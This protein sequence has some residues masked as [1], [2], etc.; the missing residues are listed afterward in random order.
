[1]PLLRNYQPVAAWSTK[2]HVCCGE[3]MQVVDSDGEVLHVCVWCSSTRR[4]HDTPAPIVELVTSARLVGANLGAKLTYD[5]SGG[6]YL[7]GHQL[8]NGKEE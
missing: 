8:T 7:D 5:P 6:W 3:K 1:M 2:P 4:P